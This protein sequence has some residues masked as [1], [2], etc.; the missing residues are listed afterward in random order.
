MKKLAFAF[1][2]VMLSCFVTCT[3]NSAH[4]GDT[5]EK[6]KKNL[7][8]FKAVISMFETGDYSKAGD[9]IANDGVDHSAP[10]TS[11]EVKGL[12]SLKAMFA[13]MTST[14]S[15]V[16]NEIKKEMSD[17]EYSMVW[18][19]Q[20]WTQTKDDPMMGMKAGQTGDMQT[21]ELCKHGAD[22]KITDHWGFM[23]MSDAM[24]MMPK[25]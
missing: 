3:N 21:V 22:G 24:K 1:S 19:R 16:K 2:L 5:S 11:G 9:Y 10:T 23:S 13:Q 6:A 15:N 14:M 12:D 25:Q 7:D 8:N 20:T 18:V 4:E 17:D